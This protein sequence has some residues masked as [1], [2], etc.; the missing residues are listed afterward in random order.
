MGTGFM[1]GL[2]AKI[3][4]YLWR[5]KVSI[6]NLPTDQFHDLLKQY[7]DEVK[8]A[9]MAEIRHQKKDAVCMQ[10]KQNILAAQGMGVSPL[11]PNSAGI[12]S[13][14]G[15]V[16]P[17]HAHQTTIPPYPWD[18]PMQ[19]SSPFTIVEQLAARMRWNFRAGEWATGFAH[20]ACQ[21]AGDSVHIWIITKDAKSVVLED[22]ASLYPSDT[23]VTKLRLM[24]QESGSK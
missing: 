9:V 20:V 22:E 6:L 3:G 4:A 24:Q 12:G 17:P 8:K 14:P 2:R 23:L 19:V 11:G 13:L 21:P 18:T 7:P 5:R 15:M 1:S 16:P 10:A